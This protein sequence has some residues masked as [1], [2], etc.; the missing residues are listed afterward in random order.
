MDINIIA[1]GCGVTRFETPAPLRDWYTDRSVLAPIVI[2]SSRAGWF[3]RACVCLST[4]NK[5]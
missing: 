2:E 3:P 4:C 5:L 1:E